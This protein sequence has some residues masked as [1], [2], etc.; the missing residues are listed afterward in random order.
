MW[1]FF[2]SSLARVKFSLFLKQNRKKK[3]RGVIK[4][5]V[6]VLQTASCLTGLE[7]LMIVPKGTGKDVDGISRD[8][9][10]L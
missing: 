4:K 5:K 2:S 7:N 10:Q 9:P 8:G 6:L 3:N 1:D